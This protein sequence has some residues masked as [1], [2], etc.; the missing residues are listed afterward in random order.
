MTEDEHK[1]RHV[2][3][4]EALDELIADWLSEQS[5]ASG[6]RPS[7]TTIMELMEWSHAQTQNP[8]SAGHTQK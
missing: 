7:N 1:Q 8:T 3:L 4:H 6:K 5:L 2:E